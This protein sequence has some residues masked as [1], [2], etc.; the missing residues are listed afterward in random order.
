MV[1][2]MMV[3]IIMVALRKS[4]ARGEPDAVILFVC[5]RAFKVSFTPYFTRYSQVF[6]KSLY[7]HSPFQLFFSPFLLERNQYE[8]LRRHFQSF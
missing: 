4:K 6:K 5:P 1:K 3:F 2:G 8:C 7:F